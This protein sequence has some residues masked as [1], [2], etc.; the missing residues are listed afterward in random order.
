M[1]PGD[2]DKSS[3]LW[4]TDPISEVKYQVSREEDPREET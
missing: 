1:R 2:A 4:I 3:N